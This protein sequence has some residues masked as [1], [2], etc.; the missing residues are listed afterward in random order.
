MHSVAPLPAL[1]AQP[2]LHPRDQGHLNAT[3]VTS[4]LTHVPAAGMVAVGRSQMIFPRFELAVSRMWS[5]S[6]LGWRVI[7]LLN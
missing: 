3:Y 1:L 4:I 7:R 5:S 2:I 6:E